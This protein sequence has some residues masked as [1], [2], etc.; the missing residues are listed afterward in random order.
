MIVTY[1]PSPEI[2]PRKPLT[3]K[4]LAEIEARAPKDED[5]IYDEDCP[6][7]TDEQL[8][9]FRRVHPISRLAEPT[10]HLNTKP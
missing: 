5:I 1:N 3:R 8:Q 10:N 2:A 7:M 6:P 4:Q 9:Q